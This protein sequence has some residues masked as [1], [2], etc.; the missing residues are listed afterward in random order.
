MLRGPCRGLNCVHSLQICCAPDFTWIRLAG[1]A[2]PHVGYASGRQILRVQNSMSVWHAPHW[3]P[4]LHPPAKFHWRI[5]S[6]PTGSVPAGVLQ[7]D[8][9]RGPSPKSR[10]AACC[11][12]QLALCLTFRL[13][14]WT[15]HSSS[16]AICKTRSESASNRAELGRSVSTQLLKLGLVRLAC[17]A[18]TPKWPAGFSSTEQSA[19]RRLAVPPP[20]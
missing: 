17:D 16:T 14:L 3:P 9:K 11:C 8:T 1:A 6:R 12:H 18:G 2:E 19:T 20:G 10:G 5:L 7:S 13:M 15:G 4:R